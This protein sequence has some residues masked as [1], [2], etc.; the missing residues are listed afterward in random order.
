M[1]RPG[2]WLMASRRPRI[3]WRNRHGPSCGSRLVDTA[4]G[5]RDWR[6]RIGRVIAWIVKFS[7][8]LLWM[9][10]MVMGWSNLLPVHWH[11]VVDV[12]R[13]R[14]RRI[15]SSP[16]ASATSPHQSERRISKRTRGMLFSI[17]L[18]VSLYRMYWFGLWTLSSSREGSNNNLPQQV[19]MIVRLVFVS[20]LLPGTVWCVVAM[21]RRD[22]RRGN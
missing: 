8:K 13:R 17:F 7:S 1:V 19:S 6:S 3:R 16:L 4:L 11:R 10:M 2:T 21:D 22:E 15:C 14:R 20:Y 12:S 18:P 5:H 9:S